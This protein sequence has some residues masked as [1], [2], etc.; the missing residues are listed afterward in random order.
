MPICHSEKI[1]NISMNMDFG[2]RLCG[3]VGGG[4]EEAAAVL[5]CFI[6]RRTSKEKEEA[7]NRRRRKSYK[8]ISSAAPEGNKRDHTEKSSEAKSERK[9]FNC[10]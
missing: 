9:L 5:E 8:G 6:R 1:L 10:P 3:G 4:N 7:L 2:C